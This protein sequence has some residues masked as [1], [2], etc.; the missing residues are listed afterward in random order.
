MSEPTQPKRRNRAL[1]ILLLLDL[2]RR[3]AA[4]GCLLFGEFGIAFALFWGLRLSTYTSALLLLRETL[5]KEMYHCICLVVVA[6]SRKRDSTLF[7]RS[8]DEKEESMCVVLAFDRFV[9]LFEESCPEARSQ[10]AAAGMWGR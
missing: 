7:E 4:P 3:L 1:E 2:A 8:W 10:P 5:E 9:E 6:E